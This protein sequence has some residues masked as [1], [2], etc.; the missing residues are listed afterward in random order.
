MS[1]DFCA[2]FNLEEGQFFPNIEGESKKQY[3]EKLAWAKDLF[4]N[5]SRPLKESDLEVNAQQ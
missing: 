2:R 1:L 4:E 3:L 5:H